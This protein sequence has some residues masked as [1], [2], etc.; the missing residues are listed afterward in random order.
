[1]SHRSTT[2]AVV[3]VAFLG[4][5]S[6]VS[7][8]TTYEVLFQNNMAVQIAVGNFDPATD[9]V[10]VRGSFNG[11]SGPTDLL[12]PDFFNDSLY[13]GIVNMDLTPPSADSAFYKYTYTNSGGVQ[14]EGGS[15]R[16]VVATG[17]ETDSNGNGIPEITVAE[18]YWSDITP[19]DIFTSV[20]DVYFE[21]DMRSA[22][23]FLA[24]SGAITYP[25]GSGN[26]VTAIDTV[27]L[28]AGFGNTT[29]SMAWVWDLTPGDPLIDSLSM[30]DDGANGDLVAGDSVYTLKVLF[31]VGAPKGITYKH[32]I[33]ALDNEA[34]FAQDWA[35]RLDTVA[36]FRVFDLFGANST[37][38]WYDNYLTAIRPSD[39]N[40]VVPEGYAVYQNY[41]NPFNPTT[42]IDF[43]ISTSE[44]VTLEVYNV[45]G[46][47][48]ATLVNGQL[49]AGAYTFTWNGSNDFGERVTSGVY[50]YRF[51]A[52]DFSQ[53]KKMILLK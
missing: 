5:T 30:K 16:I 27:N 20:T 39:R 42:N 47:K 33:A 38:G 24:D 25:P 3:L 14:W 40:A 6:A 50:I 9:T 11:W 44:R 51:T 13:V 53:T 49:N 28:A 48:V 26:N 23:Y 29:P 4:L 46:Q 34:G 37:D 8:Q 18:R 2:L 15:D 35:V 12:V 10:D 21:V 32:G 41:P 45:L 7:A 36:N 43:V 17:N 19:S 22:Y 52:G 1:M 31:E